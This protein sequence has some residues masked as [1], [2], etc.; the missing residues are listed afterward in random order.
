MD[1][2]TLLTTQSITVCE[3][4]CDAGPDDTPFAECRTGHSIAYVRSGSFG[5]RCRAGFFELV[6]GSMLVGAPGEEYTCTHEHVSG[7][8]CLG[9]FFSEDM[10]EALN[11]RREIWRI[12]ATPPLPELMVLG[13][14]A[15]TAADGNSDI[16]LDEVGQILAGR[17]ADVISGKPPKP[18]TPNAR[19]RRRAVE[20]ALWIDDNSHDEVDLEQAAK[21]AGLSPFHFL[22]LF[23]SVLGVTPHQY[24]VR[25]RLRHAARLLADDGIAVTEIA[26]DVGFGDLSNFVRTFH[27]AAGVSPTKFRQASKG[28]RSI[29]AERLVLN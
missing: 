22:R 14:L 25:S 8:V 15:Q 23:S 29:F 13:E 11:G 26:Y 28:A 2:T 6:A 5:C 9:F 1:A 19:D 7:D 12:G 21:Q 24:L 18:A 3:F 27:R 4:R 16:G 17:F 20:A 10:V